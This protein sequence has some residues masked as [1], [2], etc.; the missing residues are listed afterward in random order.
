[1]LNRL[2][3]DRRVQHLVDILVGSGLKVQNC[4]RFSLKESNRHCCMTHVLDLFAENDRQVTAIWLATT[5]SIAS[6]L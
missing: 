2:T 6:Y 4:V 1:M 5:H 3:I